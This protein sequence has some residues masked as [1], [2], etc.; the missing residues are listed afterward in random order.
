MV[1]TRRQSHI[2]AGDLPASPVQN[3]SSPSPSPSRTS[4]S[5]DWADS[6]GTGDRSGAWGLTGSLGDLVSVAGTL[7][8]IGVTPAFAIIMTFT[9]IHLD[10]SLLALWKYVQQQGL[11]GLWA[12][13]PRPTADAWTH[14]VAFGLLEAVLQLLLP[15]KQ[16]K[17]PVT[18]K[19]NQ[20]VYK[21]NGVLAYLVTMGLLALGWRTGLF[22]P[23]HVYDI[24]PEIISA[25]NIFSLG[26]C[27][28]L[29]L[30]GKYAPSSSDSGSTGSLIFDFYW[31]ME[32]YPRIGKYFDLKTWT[33]CRMGMMSWAVLIVCYAAKQ[34]Q[35][36]GG[37]ADSMLVSV[38]LMQIYIFKFFLWETGYWGSMDIMHDRAGY[39]ICWGCLVW[40]PSVYTSPGLFLAAHPVDLGV[41]LASLIFSAGVAAIYIN[42]D[43]DRQRQ[44][45]RES[46]GR[47]LVWGAKPHKITAHY[48]TG[49]GATKTS[50]LLTSGWWGL[51]RHFHYLPE[52]LAAFLWTVPATFTHV[53]PYFYVTFLTLLLTDRAF[54][55]DERCRAKYG[56]YWA[57]YSTLVP[58]KMIPYVW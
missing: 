34:R 23:G 13:W 58:Y 52:L 26:F 12:A 43:S 42:Y 24:L 3:G 7:F 30:K 22:D 55:D 57:K 8:I 56:K 5:R 54:R 19:G 18:P 39:Y 11:G 45:F 16:H 4:K 25:L 51:A 44:V 20:P 14:I 47:A 17:G 50:L 37:I 32:L 35:A 48:T 28:F 31:G 40:V 21:A 29:Y 9:Y 33:N 49:D 27:A 10:A 6:H 46:G 36:T 15:G 38:A 41:P 53:L 1:Q 2:A